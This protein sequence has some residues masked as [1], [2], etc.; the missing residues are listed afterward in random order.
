MTSLFSLA[1]KVVV[2]GYRTSSG[3]KG[4]HEREQKSIR[5]T[6]IAYTSD[7]DNIIVAAN[8][9]R[10]IKDKVDI[11]AV[12]MQHTLGFYYLR[13]QLDIPRSMVPT[14][15]FRRNRDALVHFALPYMAGKAFSSSMMG[16]LL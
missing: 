12:E 5:K 4:G 8:V 3:L 13:P 15:D 9:E 10:L 11:V 7:V 1:E 14:E 2:L 6:P 16:F